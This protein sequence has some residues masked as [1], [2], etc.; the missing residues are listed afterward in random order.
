MVGVVVV[1]V[2][3][4]VVVGVVVVLVSEGPTLSSSVTAGLH[5]LVTWGPVTRP[6]LLLRCRNSFLLMILPA[7]APE[8]LRPLPITEERKET[9]EEEEEWGWEEGAREAEEREKG[10]QVA[11][12]CA[13]RQPAGEVRRTEAGDNL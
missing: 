6:W 11:G 3:M 9:E 5:G 1:V 13:D 12:P 7:L 2:V 8:L 4:V 10:W